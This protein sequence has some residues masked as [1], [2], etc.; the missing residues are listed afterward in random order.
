MMRGVAQIF[1]TLIEKIPELEATAF[2]LIA[3]IGIKMV[4]SHWYHVGELVFFS[5]LVGV[6]LLTFLIHKFNVRRASEASNE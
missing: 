2:I 4:M 1:L 6:F 5:V 3:I